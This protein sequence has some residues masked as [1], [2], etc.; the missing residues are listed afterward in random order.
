[1]NYEII[2]PFL[3]ARGNSSWYGRAFAKI[4]RSAVASGFVNPE[5]V[6]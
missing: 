6:L 3:F 4:P 5:L 1:M 2:Q